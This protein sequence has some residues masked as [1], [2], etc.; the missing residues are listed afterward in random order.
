MTIKPDEMIIGKLYLFK[1]RDTL[2][3]PKNDMYLDFI[4]IFLGIEKSKFFNNNLAYTFFYKTRLE[5]CDCRYWC[6]E[7]L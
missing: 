4:A 7:Q 1:R 2:L 5:C 3:E 6:A